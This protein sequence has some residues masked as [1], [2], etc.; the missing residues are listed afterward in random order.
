MDPVEPVENDEALWRRAAAG[1]AA[2]MGALFR[3]HANAVY[4]HCFRR[5]GNWSTAE[6]LTSVVFLEA[7]R[8]RSRLRPSAT[9]SVLPWLLGIAT[10]VVRNH[11][12]ALGRYERALARLPPLADEADPADVAALRVDAEVEMASILPAY[13]RLRREEQDVLAL[14]AWSG[15]SYEDASIALAVP[16]GTVRSR[17][18]RARRH[19][20]ELLDRP[21]TL[22]KELR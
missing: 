1:D 18:N 21:A 13:H 17:L 16:V 4:N 5:T 7:W 3:R 14:C 10:N 19:L 20:R 2:G 8:Q 22:E 6:D 15:L 11:V 9:G 12:R